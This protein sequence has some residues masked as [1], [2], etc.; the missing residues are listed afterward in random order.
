MNGRSLRK[1]GVHGQD[2]R[3]VPGMLSDM[4]NQASRSDTLSLRSAFSQLSLRRSRRSVGIPGVRHQ[5]SEQHKKVNS[6]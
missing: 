3:D 2:I 6:G 1:Q 4:F 5:K